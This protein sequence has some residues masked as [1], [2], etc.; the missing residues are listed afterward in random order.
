M[1]DSKQDVFRRR[2]FASLI[3]RLSQ[4]DLLATPELLL[5]L[6]DNDFAY[7]NPALS[8]PVLQAVSRMLRKQQCQNLI[9][10]LP[11]AFGGNA[12]SKPGVCAIIFAPGTSSYVVRIDFFMWNFHHA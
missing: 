9:Q 1:N 12:Q 7:G 2:R 10:P 4:A 5:W 11:P 3:R 8:N 6:V